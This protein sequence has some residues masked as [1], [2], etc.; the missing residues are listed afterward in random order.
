[1]YIGRDAC[2]PSAAF[3][4]LR[5]VFV[6]LQRHR[7]EFICNVA[8]KMTSVMTDVVRTGMQHDV[9]PWPYMISFASLHQFGIPFAFVLATLYRVHGFLYFAALVLLSSEGGPQLYNAQ[10]ARCGLWSAMAVSS[11]SQGSRDASL[12]QGAG[13]C[14]LITPPSCIYSLHAVFHRPFETLTRLFAL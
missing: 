4:S 3:A 14:H 10:K 13:H 8:L 5:N 2:W 12:S 11:A 1:M 6:W 9:C 7:R